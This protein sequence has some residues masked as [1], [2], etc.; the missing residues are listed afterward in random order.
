MFS[1][2]T[3]LNTRYFIY[4]KQQLIYQR[5]ISALK[6]T[7]IQFVQW[8]G[9]GVGC[10]CYTHPIDFEYDNYNKLKNQNYQVW[11]ECF[12]FSSGQVD[13]CHGRCEED[14]EGRLSGSGQAVNDDRMGQ[15]ALLP[16]IVQ[17]RRRQRDH[18]LEEVRRSLER[19]E[20]SVC[21]MFMS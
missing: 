21:Q 20:K 12:G 9:Y 17:R 6:T 15:H 5:F 10:L 11:D 7:I 1:R 3:L 14:E 8:A 2:D 19:K 13:L 16:V 4:Q 18:A